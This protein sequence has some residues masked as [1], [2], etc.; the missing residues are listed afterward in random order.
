MENEVETKEF[1]DAIKA[2]HVLEIWEQSMREGTEAREVWEAKN[3]R[4]CLV[5]R[6]FI[7]AEIILL[8]TTCLLLLALVLK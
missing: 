3:D 7:I 6:R 5:S 8:S 1:M 4:R 2:V